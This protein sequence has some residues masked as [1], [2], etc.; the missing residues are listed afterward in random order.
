MRPNLRR[1]CL[2]LGLVGA[3]ACPFAQASAAT[4]IASVTASS[5]KPLSLT[6]TQSLDLGTISLGPGTWSGATVGISR[7]GLFSCT[8]AK[9]VC[10]G[11][12]KVAAY[13]VAGSN[14]QV[15]RI[16]APNVTLTNQNNPSQTLTLVVDSPATVTLPNSGVNGADFSIGGSIALSSATATGTYSGTFNVTVDY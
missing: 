10:T 2:I 14:G 8:G 1:L 5:L 4:I 3:N 11:L 7:A 15:V 12:T 6:S 13:T 16:T 9:L